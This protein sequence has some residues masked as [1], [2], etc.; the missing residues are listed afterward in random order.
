MSEN[1]SLDPTPALSEERKAS[2]CSAI[3]K[4]QR[5]IS[6]A[7]DNSPFQQKVRLMLATK[8]RSSAEINFAKSL[9]VDLIGENRVQELLSKYDSIEKDNLEIHF[10]GALQTNKVKYIID[11]VSM[12]HS[13]DR[14]SLAQ[15]INRQAEKK[16]IIMN[17]LCEVNIGNEQSKSG[18]HCDEVIPFL[19]TVCHLPNIKVRG[20]MAIPPIITDFSTQKQY[21]QKIMNLYID[22]SAKK[23]DNISMNVLS[24][25]MSDDY[26]LAI[27]HG[28]TL[29]RIGTACFGKRNYN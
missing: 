26:A 5:H 2:I 11:K 15:E 27:E 28:S 18:L 29:V 10:I 6:V 8:T 1:C 12:I 4:I 21:F 3:K 17:V 19:E 13:V 20:L 23:I 25:G 7:Q 16:G 24:I 9:G 14:L 22:I